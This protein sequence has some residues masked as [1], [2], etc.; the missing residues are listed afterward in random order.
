[1]PENVD[2]LQ[3]HWLLAKMGKRVL[4]PGGL[5]LTQ[6][7][8]KALDVQASDTVIEFAPGLGLSTAM[9][10]KNQPKRYIGVEVNPDAMAQIKQSLASEF[11][12]ENEQNQSRQLVC[13]HAQNTELDSGIADKLFGEAMLS[14]QSMVQKNNIIGEAARLLKNDGVYAIHELGLVDGTTDEQ[15]TTLEKALTKAIR[16]NARPMSAKEWGGML[17]VHGFDV[18]DVQ[19]APMHLLEP[20]RMIRDEGFFRTLKIVFNILT[21]PQ[22]RA[23]VRAMRRVFKANSHMMNAVMVVA[24]KRN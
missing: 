1:M 23:R 21:N 7:L 14:M 8:I 10:L 2:K 17:E 15:K 11:S 9:V 3:G 5:A 24:K 4:R 19:H 6:K 12:V 18:I 13:K 22:A 20:A 16:V